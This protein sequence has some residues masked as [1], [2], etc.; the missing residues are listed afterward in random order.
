M[1]PAFK[2]ST[3]H[4]GRTT[5]VGFL[6]HSYDMS[7]T[8]AAGAGQGVLQRD[9]PFPLKDL[10]LGICKVAAD[11]VSDSASVV[12]DLKVATMLCHDLFEV[13]KHAM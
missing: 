9:A 5:G 12:I 4:S 6:K 7:G 11:D 13:L 8:C 3:I 10:D 2:E 1:T